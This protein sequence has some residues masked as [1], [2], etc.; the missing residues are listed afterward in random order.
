MPLWPLSSCKLYLSPARI[1]PT[2]RQTSSGTGNLATTY[3]GILLY[4]VAGLARESFPGLMAVL[5]F[6]VFRFVGSTAYLIVR[7]FAGE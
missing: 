1:E 2:D 5:T 6:S 7:L 3:M 4:S